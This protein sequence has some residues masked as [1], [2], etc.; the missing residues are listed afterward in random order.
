MFLQCKC[1]FLTTQRPL[2]LV[3]WPKPSFV[4]CWRGFHEQADDFTSWPSGSAVLL[5]VFFHVPSL[6]GCQICRNV[7]VFMQWYAQKILY[8]PLKSRDIL[9]GTDLYHNILFRLSESCP[10]LSLLLLCLE[11][12]HYSCNCAETSY[13]I[14]ENKKIQLQRKEKYIYFLLFKR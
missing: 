2:S 6:C 11:D 3:E 7:V 12:Y 14:N 9:K 10:I 13:C 5:Q 4:Q 1:F 8:R